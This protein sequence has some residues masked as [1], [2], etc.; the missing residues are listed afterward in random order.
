M[1]K[2]P[3]DPVTVYI[4]EIGNI[5]PL[6]ADEEMGLFQQLAGTSSWDEEKEN[7]ARRLIEGHLAQVVSIAQKIPTRALRC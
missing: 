1:E 6:A 3:M 4:N 5:K 7:I 2:H